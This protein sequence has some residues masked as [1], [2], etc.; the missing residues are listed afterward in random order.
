MT[1]FFLPGEKQSVIDVTYPHRADLEATLASPVWVENRA[2]GFR[3]RIPA[4]EAA[5]ANKYSAML[6]LTRDPGKRAL[7][8]ADFTWMVQHSLDEGQE[9][10]ELEKLTAL[11]E[12]V[13]PGG[14]GE[15]ILRLVQQVKAGT[16]INLGSIGSHD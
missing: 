16:P 2:L 13:W 11:G 6:T 10:I 4:L 1:A 3:Y 8:V 7:D 14:G 12:K 5:L 9:P 15:E